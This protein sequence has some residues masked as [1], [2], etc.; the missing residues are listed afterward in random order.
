M[1]GIRIQRF[2]EIMSWDTE[3]SWL[4]LYSGR[5]NDSLL[6]D[7]SDCWKLM[8]LFFPVAFLPYSG[9]WPPIADGSLRSHSLD[10]PHSVWL[11]WISDQAVAEIS[12]WQHPTLPRNKRP[13][14][15]RV[16]NH[17]TS[18][19]SAADPRLNRVATVMLRR[20]IYAVFECFN[21][22]NI[23]WIEWRFIVDGAS[24]TNCV[25]YWLWNLF[26]CF[27]FMNILG[28]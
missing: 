13:C 2:P 25:C 4:F 16:S 17:E 15:P 26:L 12:T 9:S 21:S 24:P 5:P 20:S 10:A 23:S 27:I 28:W 6:K 3:R 19:R 1:L 11:L 18:K 22:I 14:P 8:L 7:L